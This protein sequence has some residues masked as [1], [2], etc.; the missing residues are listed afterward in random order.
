MLDPR[1]RPA[2][3]RSTAS[4]SSTRACMARNPVMFVVEVGSVL[5]TILFFRDLGDVDRDGERLRRARRRL[6]VVHRPL[7]QLRRGDGRRPGQGAG[8]RPCARPAPR[9]SRTAP[10]PTARIEEVASS[11]LD[12]RRRGR[13][14]GGRDD[15]GRRRGGRGHR[16]RRRVGHHRRV[17]ARDPR[18]GR[19]PLGGHR[20]AP[21]ALRPRSSCASPPGRAR[22]S[23]TA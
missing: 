18:V 21:G 6:A 10:A 16:Q 13:C 19:R 14:L 2:G 5:T 20:A 23:S 17:G 3:P 4:A 12:G 7:R 11:Q 22:P 9:R 1:D 15:P 8:R